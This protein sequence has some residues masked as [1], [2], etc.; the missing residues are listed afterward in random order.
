MVSVPARIY[1]V[2]FQGVAA[3]VQQDFFTI[4]P[5][6]DKP[7]CVLEAHVTQSSD[8]GDAQ[9]EQLSVTIVTGNTVAASGGSAF[10]PLPLVTGDAAA[11]FTARIN[12]TTKASSGTAA[13]KHSE[14]FNVRSGFHYVPVPEAR[15]VVSQ[16]SGVILAVRL[17]TTPADSLTIDG[18]LL[19]AEIG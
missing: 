3:T 2:T 12:D 6:D 15:I 1:T 5:G 4:T 16:S 14:S 11:T 10:T 13:V 7:V 8:A 19:V 17:N 18:T 9:D